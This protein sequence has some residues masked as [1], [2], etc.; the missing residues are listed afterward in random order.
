MGEINL[1]VAAIIQ[2]LNK[3][4][5]HKEARTLNISRKGVVQMPATL[6]IK[7]TKAHEKD[8]PQVREEAL[9]EIRTNQCINQR[10]PNQEMTKM[11]PK[12]SQDH[13]VNN[14]SREVKNK[15]IIKKI[16]RI[17]NMVIEITIT[18][19][20]TSVNLVALINSRIKE[21]VGCP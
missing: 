13:M 6:T 3:D 4:T 21:W 16:S 8:T 2:P 14:T 19:R 7:A 10:V 1:A 15:I 5:N 18:S 11:A 20:T 12:D 9:V 17:L